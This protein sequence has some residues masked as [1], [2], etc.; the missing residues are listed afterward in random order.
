MW[1]RTDSWYYFQKKRKNVNDLL[2]KVCIECMKN[3]VLVV[4][5]GRESIKLGPPISIKID[6]LKEGLKVIDQSI[7]KIFQ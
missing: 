1:Q 6:A 2:K 4:Y 7:I 3:G 5:T